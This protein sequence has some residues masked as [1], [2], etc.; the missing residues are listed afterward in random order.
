MGSGGDKS[1]FAVNVEYSLT[2]IAGIAVGISANC[3][4]ARRATTKIHA[5]GTIEKLDNPNWFD[6]R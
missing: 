3:W 5:D 1:V 2:H 6:G 4:I